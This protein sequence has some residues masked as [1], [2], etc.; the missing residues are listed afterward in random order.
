MVGSMRYKCAKVKPV[1]ELMDDYFSPSCSS[2]ESESPVSNS[3]SVM[4]QATVIAA[5][6]HPPWWILIT[7]ITPERERRFQLRPGIGFM[8]C[9]DVYHV[10]IIIIISETD[11]F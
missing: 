3:K 5:I 4:K 9:N 11:R 1:V 7:P 2:Q 6:R 10:A 8:F